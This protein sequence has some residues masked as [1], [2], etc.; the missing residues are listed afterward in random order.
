MGSDVKQLSLTKTTSQSL[1]SLL[2]N[3]GGI[4]A[5][6][7]VAVSFGLFSREPW[8]FAL[9]PGILSMRGVIGGLFSGRLSTALHLGTIRANIFGEKSK[10]FRLLQSSIVVL[11]FVSSIL[12]GL[13]A[14]FFGIVFLELNFFDMLAI[15]SVLLATMGLSLLAISPITMIVAFSSFNKGLDPDIIVYPIISTVADILV[16]LCYVLVLSLSFLGTMGSFVVLIICVVFSYVTLTTF[17]NSKNEA[18]FTRTIK[19]ALRTMVIVAFIVNIT[20]SVLSRI[21]SRL[22]VAGHRPEIYTVYPA[23][24][25]TMGDVGAIIGSTAT[26][27]LALGALDSSFRSIKDHRNQIAGA[28]LAS[29]VMCVIYALISSLSQVSGNLFATLRFVGLLL[30]TNA[31][32]AVFMIT[33]SFSVAI[34]TFHE[35]L[36]PDNFV[37]PIESSLADTITTISLLIMLSLIG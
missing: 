15:F 3:L 29:L 22:E 33:I 18:E 17:R 16:T 32:S 6:S 37:I 20:G 26:T 9:Y 25:D 4:L 5:G 14:L 12:L 28:W 19:E 31:F 21:V 36:D 23:L 34:L 8:M 30:A 35:G 24:I 1:L 2:F 7:I 10:H 11:T 27:K 13:V